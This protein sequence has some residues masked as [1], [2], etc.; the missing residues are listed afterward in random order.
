VLLAP[1]LAA[2]VASHA[3]K[4]PPGRFLSWNARRRT[5][6]V[7]LVAAYDST[8]HGFNFD[9]YGRGE[10]LVTVPVGWR[11]SVLCRNRGPLR[12]SCAVVRGPMEAAPAF[13]GATTADP[14]AGLEAGDSAR[15][16][17]TASRV[18]TFRLACLVPGHEEARM[19]DVLDVARSSRP[20]IVAR[21]GP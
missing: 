1:L 16:T 3:A 19:W 6:T 5:A 2:A 12:H 8:N 14:V 10:L 7:T 17:F 21:P 20:S 9:G 11:I 18:G 4:P 13:R 15:F